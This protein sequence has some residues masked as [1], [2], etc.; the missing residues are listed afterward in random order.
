MIKAVTTALTKNASQMLRVV[1]LEGCS[2]RK[3]FLGIAAE[4]KFSLQV[5]GHQVVK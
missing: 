3:A 2:F 4:T 5:S 1:H